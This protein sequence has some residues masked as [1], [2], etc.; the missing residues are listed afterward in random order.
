VGEFVA[1]RTTVTAP[2]QTRPVEVQ[3]RRPALTVTP[4]TTLGTVIQ[5]LALNRIHQVWVV[6][7]NQHPVGVVRTK[8]IVSLVSRHEA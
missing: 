8:A 5:L 2:G 6:D 1:R 4:K 3:T 7:E